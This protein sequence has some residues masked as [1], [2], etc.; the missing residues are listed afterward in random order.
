MCVLCFV[1][2]SMSVSAGDFVDCVTNNGQIVKH[3]GQF[4]PG[5]DLCKVCFCENGVPTGCKSVLCTPSAECRA[6]QIGSFC[7]D[8]ICIEKSPN[9]TEKEPDLIS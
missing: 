1:I 7:C 5:N 2:G 9:N 8:F 3:G 6:F 4:I